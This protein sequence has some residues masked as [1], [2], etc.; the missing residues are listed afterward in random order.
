MRF[1]KSGEASDSFHIKE[2][3]TA[4][5][6]KYETKLAYLERRIAH[7]FYSDY[8][9]KMHIP[10]TSHFFAFFPTVNISNYRKITKNFHP[11]LLYYHTTHISHVQVL[12]SFTYNLNNTVFTVLSTRS[13]ISPVAIKLVMMGH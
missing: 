3:G 12:V 4:N 13:Q 9:L 5:P 8:F 2:N 10:S 1:T 7:C 6:L 11:S